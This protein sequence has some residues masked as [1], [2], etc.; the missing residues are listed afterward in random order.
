[1][2]REQ[3]VKPLTLTIQLPDEQMAVLVAKAPALG[4]SAEE[5]AAE[6]LR[7]DLAPEWLQRSWK[8]AEAEGLNDLS[9]E[10]IAAEI[11]AARVARRE[12]KSQPGA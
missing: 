5:Y 6:A 9:A 12:P 1:V 4:L 7:H 11:A 2:K 10:E 8:S 3:G